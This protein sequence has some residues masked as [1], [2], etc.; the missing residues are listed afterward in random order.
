MPRDEGFVSSTDLDAD[1]HRR[2]KALCCSDEQEAYRT[3]DEIGQLGPFERASPTLTPHRDSG[4]TDALPVSICCDFDLRYLAALHR[5]LPS[6]QL[7][8][9][10]QPSRHLAASDS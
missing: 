9:V 7:V 2:E 6:V 3:S 1:T 4:Q 10:A 8:S 5:N